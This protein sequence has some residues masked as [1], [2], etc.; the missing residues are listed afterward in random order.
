MSVQLMT[1]DRAKIKAAAA[2]LVERLDVDCTEMDSLGRYVI[3]FQAMSDLVEAIDE[4]E[5][6][7]GDDD[8]GE[9]S[10]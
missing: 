1:I 10:P 7:L 6:A 5:D 3:D 8:A 9:I 4:I 2:T